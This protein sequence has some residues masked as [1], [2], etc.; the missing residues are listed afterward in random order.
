MCR[1]FYYLKEENNSCI[2]AKTTA[3]LLKTKQRDE[4]TLVFDEQHNL[5]YLFNDRQGMT[6]YSVKDVDTQ[7][8]L[9]RLVELDF[10]T[11]EAAGALLLDAE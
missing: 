5:L 10:L 4:H 6:S 9:T 7:D 1:I 3:Y 11:E 8:F 2:D